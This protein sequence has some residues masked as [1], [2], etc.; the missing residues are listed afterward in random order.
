MGIIVGLVVLV[1]AVVAG[2]VIWRKKLSGRERREG[3]EFSSL[4]GK[5]SD[6]GGCFLPRYWKVPSTHMWRLELMLKFSFSK[7]CVKMKD[8]FFTFLIPVG[9]QVSST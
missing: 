8:K 1:V 9:D 6:P 5:V 2:A 7:T 3:S 4:T